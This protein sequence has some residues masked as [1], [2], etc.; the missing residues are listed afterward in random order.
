MQF[1]T[2]AGA[3][4]QQLTRTTLGQCFFFFFYLRALI[5]N[6]RSHQENLLL[7]EKKNGGN[8][9]KILTIHIKQKNEMGLV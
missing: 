4:D 2:N 3:L 5:V 6:H 9:T 7:E 8:Y 1:G